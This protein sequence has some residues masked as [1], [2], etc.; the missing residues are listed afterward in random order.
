MI[1]QGHIQTIGILV[2]EKTELQ[3][4][5][6]QADYIAK[7]K[8]AEADDYANKLKD[9]HRKLTSYEQKFGESA[10]NE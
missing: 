10:H 8:A 3:A 4:A 9:L 2:A 5:V 1:F 7:R 6:T